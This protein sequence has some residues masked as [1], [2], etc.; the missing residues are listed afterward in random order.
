MFFCFKIKIC[1]KLK[2]LKYSDSSNR[3][4]FSKNF[5]RINNSENLN[6]IDLSYKSRKNINYK[7]TKLN[8]F[9]IRYTE[10]GTCY[11]G[12]PI[13]TNFPETLKEI[14]IKEIKSYKFIL[15][16]DKL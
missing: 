9:E 15:L 12:T 7:V 3:L 8:N 16:K 13:C 2:F 11:L 6:V 1:I 4:L 5:I 10:D 14:S